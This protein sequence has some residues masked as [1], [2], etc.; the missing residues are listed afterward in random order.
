[1]SAGPNSVPGLV[2]ID[3]LPAS[4]E[5]P[6]PVA[7]RDVALLPVGGDVLVNVLSNDTDPAGGILVV[8]SVSAVPGSVSPPRCWATRPCASATSVVEHA[9][10]R[11]T[12]SQRSRTAE[13]EIVVIPV[14]PPAKLRPP[15]ANDDQAVVRVGDTVTI[16]VLANDY[17]PNGDT[18]H[19]APTSCLSGRPRRRRGVRLRGQ[20]PLRAGSTPKTVYVTYEAVDSTGQRDAGTSRSRSCRA[21]TRPTPR[22]SRAI[23]PRTLSGSTVTI[24]PLDGIDQ[25]GDSGR[26]GRH[27]RRAEEGAHRRDRRELVHLRGIRRLRGRRPVLYRV[28]DSLGKDATAPP[29]RSDRTR[30]IRRRTPTPGARPR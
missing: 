16:P 22:R 5:D 18:M 24:V 4:N 30:G 29:S 19:V 10:A 13:G 2:R 14:P 11:R 26:A 25:D 28:R 27:R 6:P 20:G 7:V 1:V 12:R 9:G 21:M 8:Q 3:V 23:S 15:V 17:H